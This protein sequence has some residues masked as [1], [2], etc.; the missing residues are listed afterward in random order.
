[1]MTMMMR[2]LHIKFID[3][4]PVHLYVCP[5][6]FGVET[7][8]HGDMALLSLPSFAP[9]SLKNMVPYHGAH[10]MMIRILHYK[11]HPLS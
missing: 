11:S 6:W 8:V 9:A 1:M 5:T 4:G 2:S 3:Y 7:Q 10:M